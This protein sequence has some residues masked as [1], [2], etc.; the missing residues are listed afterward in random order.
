MDDGC[1]REE[2]DAER[3]F[4]IEGRH[5]IIASGGSG[6]RNNEPSGSLHN[7]IEKRGGQS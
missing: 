6:E 2:L 1:V 5:A 7:K 3:R 4:R